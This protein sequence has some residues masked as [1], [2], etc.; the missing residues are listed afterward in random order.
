MPNAGRSKPERNCDLLKSSAKWQQFLLMCFWKPTLLR[1]SD[2]QNPITLIL[3]M[4]LSVPSFWA[5]RRFLRLE[6][7]HSLVHFVGRCMPS[8]QRRF[9]VHRAVAWLPCIALMH[10]R[11]Q[12]Q[13][14]QIFQAIVRSSLGLVSESGQY[15]GSV[16]ILF[17]G[18]C[19]CSSVEINRISC[20]KQAPAFANALQNICAHIAS[21][22][23][24]AASVLPALSMQS[25]VPFLLHFSS[26]RYGFLQMVPQLL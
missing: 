14:R 15:M 3:A 5:A 8:H 23:C 11:S 21:C 6:S 16:G 26:N 19:N 2:S 22:S 4:P 12:V 20:R 7:S 25:R 9:V 18:S 10:V 1:P 17:G 24:R 13:H